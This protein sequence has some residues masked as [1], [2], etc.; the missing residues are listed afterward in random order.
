[1]ELLAAHQGFRVQKMKAMWLDSFYVSLLSEKYKHQKINP[2]RAFWNGCLSN[3]Q[4]L[5]DCK[6]SSSIIYILE[7]APLNNF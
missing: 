6:K 3:Y 5:K 7:F 4:A 2:I 1:M